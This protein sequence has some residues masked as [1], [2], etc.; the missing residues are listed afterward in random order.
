MLNI[1]TI[2]DR[3]HVYH[4]Q[5]EVSGEV[6]LFLVASLFVAKIYIKYISRIIESVHE[7]IIL[8]WT[9]QQLFFVC[10]E[11]ASMAT[12]LSY[13]QSDVDNLCDIPEKVHQPLSFKFPKCFFGEK[14]TV[15]RCFLPS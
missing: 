2:V 5:G 10:E 11:S 14:K 1:V 4:I 15:L 6:G 12:S 9:F 3:T 8:T 13:L 7:Q